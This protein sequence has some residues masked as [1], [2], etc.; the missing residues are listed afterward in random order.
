M[1][2]NWQLVA[3][4]RRYASLRNSLILQIQIIPTIIRM[5]NYSSL[6]SCPHDNLTKE[7]EIL[8]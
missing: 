8:P 3:S 7:E 6:F 4:R 5:L 1:A 2:P